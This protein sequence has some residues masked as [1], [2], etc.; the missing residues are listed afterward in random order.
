MC[1]D[2]TKE[3]QKTLVQRNLFP[4]L[5]PDEQAITDR[6]TDRQVQLNTLC[7]ELNMPVSQLSPL[8]FELEMKGIVRCMPGGMYRLL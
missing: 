6:L 7:I 8:L 5:T 1:W 4:D 2:E 3:K